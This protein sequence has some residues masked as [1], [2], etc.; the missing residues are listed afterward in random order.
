MHEMTRQQGPKL[1]L[2]EQHSLKFSVCRVRSLPIPP[3]TLTNPTFAAI[4]WKRQ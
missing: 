2:V 4:D 1:Q 3:E